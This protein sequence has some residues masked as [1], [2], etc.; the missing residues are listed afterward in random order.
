M[1]DYVKHLCVCAEIT[2]EYN[3]YEC[4]ITGGSCMY[5]PPDQD[6][7]ADEYGE[8]EHT[9]AWNKGKKGVVNEKK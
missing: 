3:G 7:C 5:L 4:S 8:V 6:R 1:L 2:D 9:D